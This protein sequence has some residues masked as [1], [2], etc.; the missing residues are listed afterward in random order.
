MKMRV[1]LSTVRIEF[2]TYLV[3]PVWIV[4]FLLAPVVYSIVTLIIFKRANLENYILYVLIGS[5]ALGMWTG[6]LFAGQRAIE[7]ERHAGTIEYVL[8]TP[9]SL[10]LIVVGKTVASSLIGLTTLVVILGVFAWSL[11]APITVA[12]PVAFL[13]ALGGMLLTLSVMGVMLSTFFVL[14]RSAGALVN[15][16]S[17]SV[18]VLCGIMFPVAL[19]PDWVKPVSYILSPTWGVEAARKAAL[20]GI[21]PD[22]YTDIAV[23]FLL[24]AV[25]AVVTHFLFQRVVYMAKGTGEVG[26]Y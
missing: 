5:G 11:D 25:Y 14:S 18:F 21:T 24:T 3:K 26:R 12:H 19:L 6:T 7:R 15:A 10:Q 20:E 13:V 8:V 9:S 22:F 4:E 1:I 23:L 16:L 2:L 17:R